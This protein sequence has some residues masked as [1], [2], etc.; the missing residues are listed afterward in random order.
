MA[1]I[2]TK[3][4]IPTYSSASTYAKFD[5]VKVVNGNSFYYFVSALDNNKNNLNT[6]T[7]V[8]SVW[9]KRFDD[10]TT[11]FADVWQASY[12]TSADVSPR[13]IDATLDEGTTQL[14][15]DGIN[16]VRLA[17]SL[18]FENVS[19]KEALSL[20][21]YFDYQGATRAF[22]WTTPTP[23]EKRLAFQ[24]VSLRHQYLK[25]NVNSVNISIEQSFAIFGS[26]AGQQKFG[27]F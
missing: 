17:F 11:D 25:K 21:T 12:S 1:E 26:G 7:Y 10:Y 4:N 9:W 24:L 14:A 22:F 8:S 15:R 2:I 19:D 27:A 20:L 6:G 16:S 5:V 23:Y 3:F 18:V 13:I